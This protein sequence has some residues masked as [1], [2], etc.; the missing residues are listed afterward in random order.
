MWLL[1]V[2]ICLAITAIGLVTHVII[3]FNNRRYDHGIV[4]LTMKDLAV[5]FLS[6]SVALYA[7][8]LLF[9][10]FS[11]PPRG[12]REWI[13]HVELACFESTS[14]TPGNVTPEGA[15]KFRDYTQGYMP[16]QAV[17]HYENYSVNLIPSG[18]YALILS[19]LAGAL[20]TGSISAIRT[21]RGKGR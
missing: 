21:I 8:S 15:G 9:L 14:D 3:V 16:P 20:V 10:S 11:N 2:V 1:L 6:F 18:L 17:C 7:Y 19:L 4:K 13:Y 5:L 12:D